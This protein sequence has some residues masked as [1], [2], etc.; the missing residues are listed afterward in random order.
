MC[1][2]RMDRL[3]KGKPRP[4]I[5]LRRDGSHGT[6][7]CHWC[8]RPPHL[9]HT[10]RCCTAPFLPGGT[11]ISA[12]NSPARNAH[13]HR[14]PCLAAIFPHAAVPHLQPGRVSCAAFCCTGSLGCRRPHTG[15]HRAS[16]RQPQRPVIRLVAGGRPNASIPSQFARFG[17]SGHDHARDIRPQCQSLRHRRP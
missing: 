8:R 1:A 10:S 13:V 12:V 16:R 6:C 17:P 3:P 9:A 15:G 5:H 2:W 11:L 4:L 7:C 14:R